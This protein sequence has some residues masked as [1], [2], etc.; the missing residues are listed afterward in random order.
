MEANV[1][2][3]TFRMQRYQVAILYYLGSKQVLVHR[4]TIGTL[5]KEAMDLY[6]LTFLPKHC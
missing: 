3:P 1:P 2:D 6:C 4:G 5:P